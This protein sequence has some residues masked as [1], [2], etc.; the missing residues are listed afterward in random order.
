MVFINIMMLLNL[1]NS[2]AP[3]GPHPLYSQHGASHQAT[4]VDVH[5]PL[6]EDMLLKYLVAND[7]CEESLGYLP[8]S[9]AEDA[10]IV[11]Q[12]LASRV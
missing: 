3:G 10:S 6:V 1:F 11:T 2:P 5:N 8:C 4:Q 7:G 12:G 9:L